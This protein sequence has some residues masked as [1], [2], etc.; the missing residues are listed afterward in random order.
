MIVDAVVAAV[1]AAAN[2]ALAVRDDAAEAPVAAGV[3]AAETVVA[4]V[5][6]VARIAVA[7]AYTVVA[8][9]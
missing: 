4:A 1:V 8:V 9:D 2:T 7:P 6:E 5:V 3:A